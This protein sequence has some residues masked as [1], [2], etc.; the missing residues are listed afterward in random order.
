[1]A[2]MILAGKY[3]VCLAGQTDRFCNIKFLKEQGSGAH[4]QYSVN[5]SL[6]K[7]R[8]DNIRMVKDLY[9]LIMDLQRKGT[10]K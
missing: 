6:H 9:H 2:G 5:H 7:C 1:M 10:R 8:H 4:Q 3:N